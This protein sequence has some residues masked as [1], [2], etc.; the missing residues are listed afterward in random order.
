MV[1]SDVQS[2]VWPTVAHPYLVLR[3]A[4]CHNVLSTSVVVTVSSDMFPA[5][6]ACL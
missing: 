4:P 2:I 5:V 6:V 1:H 3:L